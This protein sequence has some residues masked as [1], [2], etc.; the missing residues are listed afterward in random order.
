MLF[1]KTKLFLMIFLMAF[2][3]VTCNDWSQLSLVSKK[4]IEAKEYYNSEEF[5]KALNS[6]NEAIKFADGKQDSYFLLKANILYDKQASADEVIAECKK[7]LAINSKNIEAK[8]LMADCLCEKKDDAYKAIMDEI[9][10]KTYKDYEILAKIAHVYYTAK[11]PEKSLIYLNEALKIKSS[12]NI[13]YKMILCYIDLHKNGEAISLCE[14]ILK[15]YPNNI[16]VMNEKIYSLNELGKYEE[17]IEVANKSLSID[18]DNSVAYYELS[19]SYFSIKNYNLALLNIN[20]Y[21]ESKPDNANGYLYRSKIKKMLT[22]TK[23]MQE[24]M[25]IY[26]NKGGNKDTGHDFLND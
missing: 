10:S 23:G 1:R 20:K 6:I 21:I 3:F 5:E 13:K 14:E 8:I 22:D 15:E 4:Y 16:K 26:I 9:T 19:Y 2:A 17:A 18:K 7:A 25:Q 11:D 12:A 24:D